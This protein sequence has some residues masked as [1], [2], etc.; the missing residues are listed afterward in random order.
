[1]GKG[2]WVGFYVLWTRKISV[3]S[4]TLITLYHYFQERFLP[5]FHASA[6]DNVIGYLGGLFHSGMVCTLYV[7]IWLVQISTE[8]LVSLVHSLLIS[9]EHVGICFNEDFVWYSE[10]VLIYEFGKL[11]PKFVS[12]TSHLIPLAIP[13]GYGE[14]ACESRLE[15]RFVKRQLPGFRAL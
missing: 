7:P 5:C 1:M 2:Y 11:H 8:N 3:R 6:G 13:L 10:Q 12:M 15:F 4:L 14:G 9:G